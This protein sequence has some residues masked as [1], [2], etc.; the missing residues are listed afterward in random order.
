[1]LPGASLLLQRGVVGEKILCPYLVL[2]IQTFF[3]LSEIDNSFC[4]IDASIVFSQ[5]PRIP[6]SCLVVATQLFS[7]YCASSFTVLHMPSNSRPLKNPQTFHTMPSCLLT[8][9]SLTSRVREGIGLGSQK[10]CLV[11]SSASSHSLLY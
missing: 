8:P 7:A 9:F 5:C 11:V 6:L 4:P 3:I 1:M 10:T 2:E